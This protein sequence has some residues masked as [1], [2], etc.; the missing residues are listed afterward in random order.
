MYSIEFA[1]TVEKQL[2]KLPDMVQE[3]ILLALDRIK[4]NPFRYVKRKQGTPY[5]ILRIG[6]YRAILDIKQN[7]LI[8]LVLEIGPRKKVYK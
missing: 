6:S 7:K 8:I 4:I 1:K 3:R 5:F 2:D